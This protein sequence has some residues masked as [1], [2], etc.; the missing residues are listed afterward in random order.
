[1]SFSG[2]VKEEISKL[3]NLANKEAVKYEL[4]GYI[5]TNNISTEKNKIKF[6][7]ESEYSINRYS[8]LLNNLQYSN[9]KIE[10]IGKKFCI[11]GYKNR[12]KQ[13]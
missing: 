4:L 13:Y 2:E 8:K 11:N 7:T 10:I 3:S 6:C 5:I 9:H 12:I 1:M